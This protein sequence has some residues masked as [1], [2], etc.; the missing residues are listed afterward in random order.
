MKKTHSSSVPRTSTIRPELAVAIPDGDVQAD[1]HKAELLLAEMVHQPL[2]EKGNE[3]VDDILGE[4]GAED[5]AREDVDDLLGR[6]LGV[7]DDEMV[8][9]ARRSAAVR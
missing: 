2:R 8:S 5:G 1:G 7:D 9:A 3:G 4:S 6:L